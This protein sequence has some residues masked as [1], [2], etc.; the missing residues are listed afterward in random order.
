MSFGDLAPDL[1]LRVMKSLTV[2]GYDKQQAILD[3]LACKR[4]CRA[5]RTAASDEAVWHLSLIHI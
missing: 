5:L 1:Y 2:G 3:L 4:T